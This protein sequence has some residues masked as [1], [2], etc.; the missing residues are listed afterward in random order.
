MV[1]FPARGDPLS[2][3]LAMRL[4]QAASV[5]GLDAVVISA[6]DLPNCEASW[7][8]ERTAL[9]VDPEACALSGRAVLARLAGAA[10]RGAVAVDELGSEWYRE[11]VTLGV[12]FDVVIDVGF[13]DRPATRPVGTMPH[14]F[15]FNAPLPSEHALIADRKSPSGRPLTWSLVA[16]CTIETI[17][18]AEDL[19]SAFG[20][21][22]FTFLPTARPDRPGGG[23]G[24]DDLRRVLEGTT[25]HVWPAEHDAAYRS[26]SRF[27]DAVLCGAVPCA[28]DRGTAP[29]RLGTPN[30]FTSVRDLEHELTNRPIGELFEA[31]RTFALAHGTLADHLSELLRDV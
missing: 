20:P 14:R 19:I 13:V 29:I 2:G 4:G 26:S 31:S 12:E 5:L 30:V 6:S 27:L 8:E 25:L 24:P 7:I 28:I 10:F 22:G 3:E 21:E 23:L 17:R 16:S 11:P 9:V 15:L 1:V 18:L